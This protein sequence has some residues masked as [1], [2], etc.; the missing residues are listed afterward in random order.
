M[1]VS[2]ASRGLS[3]LQQIR[4]V[5]EHPNPTVVKRAPQGLPPLGPSASPPSQGSASGHYRA[6]KA[7]P[8]TREERDKV[9]IL[10]GGLHWRA[11]APVQAAAPADS[12]DVAA[13]PAL[14]PSETLS[15]LRAMTYSGRP[16]A[17]R[18]RLEQIAV[19]HP[20]AAGLCRRWRRLVDAFEF[21]ALRAQLR[22]PDDS[23]A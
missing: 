20:Q 6:Y 8:F 12:G 19:E 11:D 10:F 2:E 13:D 22:I 5:T 17:L 21:D 4:V 3:A 14:L 23:N 7:R 9:T 16:Q 18:A 1:S 15:Q